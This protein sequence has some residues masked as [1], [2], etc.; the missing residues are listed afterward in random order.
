MDRIG[1]SFYISEMKTNM[2]SVNKAFLSHSVYDTHNVCC[3]ARSDCETSD[4]YYAKVQADLEVSP[5]WCECYLNAGIY[6]MKFW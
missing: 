6:N 1:Q 2:A 5:S 4:E 3:D